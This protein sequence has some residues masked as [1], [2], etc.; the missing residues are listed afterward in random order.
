MG[1][2]ILSWDRCRP[3]QISDNVDALYDGQNDRERQ[4]DE[5]YHRPT[6]KRFSSMLSD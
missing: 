4:G 2:G 6:L 5:S 1:T 3:L